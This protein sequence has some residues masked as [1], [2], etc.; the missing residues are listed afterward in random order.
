MSI[1]AS[2]IAKIILGGSAVS[3]GA[4]GA[5]SELVF[6][7]SKEEPLSTVSS[8]SNEEQWRARS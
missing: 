5:L 7:E 3:F 4:V 8:K 2:G 1:L 6:G